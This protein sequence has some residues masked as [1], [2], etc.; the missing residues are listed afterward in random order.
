MCTMSTDGNTFK[1][2]YELYTDGQHILCVLQSQKKWLLIGYFKNF[3]WNTHCII[4]QANE[5][6]VDN[7]PGGKSHKLSN[8]LGR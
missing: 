3:N 4:R 6:W 1:P 7:S 5:I 8:I 2:M